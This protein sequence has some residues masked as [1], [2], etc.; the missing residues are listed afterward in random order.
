MFF[1][2]S[3]KTRAMLT[4][5]GTVSVILQQIYPGN[6]VLNFISIAQAL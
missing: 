1:N 3:H 5:F 6:S 4:K 2:I